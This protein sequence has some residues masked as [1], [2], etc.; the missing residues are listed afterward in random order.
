MKMTT[1]WKWF[2]E[3]IPAHTSDWKE[4]VHWQAKSYYP[5]FHHHKKGVY[6]YRKYNAQQARERHKETKTNKQTNKQ[7][8]Q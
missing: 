1:S 8:Q 4:T 3:K 5:F 6:Y 2:I 7:K